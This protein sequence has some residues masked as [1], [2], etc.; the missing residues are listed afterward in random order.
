MLE[1]PKCRTKMLLKKNVSPFGKKICL[2]CN[3][4][5]FVPPGDPADIEEE[6]KRLNINE[7]LQ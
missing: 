2:K 4:E 6:I 7:G 1:C 5:E 3:Y